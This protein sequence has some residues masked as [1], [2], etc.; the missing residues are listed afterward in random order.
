[1]S[2]LAY[3]ALLAF[4]FADGG[5][6]SKGQA[7]DASM[8][9]PTS[10]APLRFTY[11][12]IDGRAISTETLRNRI[13]VIGFLTTYDMA[14]QQQARYLALLERH[15]TPRINVAVLMLEAPENLPLVEAFA[16]SLGLKCPV[17]IADSATIAGEGPFTGL[18]HVP[19]VVILDR[20]GREAWRHVSFVNEAG[21]EAAVRAVEASSPPPREE[22]DRG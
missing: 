7:P 17:A 19:S 3:V 6:G 2:R 14:S 13:S 9:A 18:H 1:M 11:T 5:C 16:T 21:L 22:A 10:T 12:A 15:H 8:P 4:A 20:A